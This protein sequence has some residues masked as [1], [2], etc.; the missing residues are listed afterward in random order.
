MRKRLTFEIAAL[1]DSPRRIIALRYYVEMR[2]FSWLFDQVTS[3]VE[4]YR[5]AQGIRRDVDLYVNDVMF[6]MKKAA[7]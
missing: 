6:G 1:T 2:Q 4:L 7:P 5:I 3:D